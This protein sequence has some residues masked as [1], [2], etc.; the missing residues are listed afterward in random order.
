MNKE[1]TDQELNDMKN[2][3]AF[4]LN[5]ISKQGLSFILLSAMAFYFQSQ[6]EALQA[7]TDTCNE[8]II[9][10]YQKQSQENREVIKDNTEAIRNFSM[11]LRESK[12]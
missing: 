6:T 3:G 7:K 4:L 5:V 11:Y 9:E 8:R 12:K 2:F 10:M 1:F